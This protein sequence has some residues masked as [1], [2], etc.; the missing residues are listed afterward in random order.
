[1]KTIDEIIAGALA[2]AITT[3]EPAPALKSPELQEQLDAVRGVLRLPPAERQAALASIGQR[4]TVLL[5]DRLT[6]GMMTART[7]AVARDN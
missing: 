4:A 2:I 5:L 6:V 1:M 7:M 3:D